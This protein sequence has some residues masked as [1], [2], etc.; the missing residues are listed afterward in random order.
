[1]AE[2]KTKPTEVSVDDFIEAV[3][4]PQRRE[5]A[6]KVR[7]MMERVSGTPAR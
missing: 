1:M 6:K 3:P 7:A 5:D 4:D 2:L